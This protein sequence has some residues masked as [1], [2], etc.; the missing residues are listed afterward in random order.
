MLPAAPNGAFTGPAAKRRSIAEFRRA[1]VRQFAA[2]AIALTEDGPS[3]AAP[4]D[5]LSPGEH[6]AI[7]G[8]DRAASS[9]CAGRPVQ[10]RAARSSRLRARR[11]VLA[12]GSQAQEKQQLRPRRGGA[13]SGAA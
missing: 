3:V 5:I 4:M 1:S 12:C 6:N 2:V 13:R 11:L 7:W 9:P 10:T 8:G